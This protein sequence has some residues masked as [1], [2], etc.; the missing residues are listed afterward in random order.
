MKL[1]IK[2][3]S[4]TL[5][6]LGIA[7]DCHADYADLMTSGKVTNISH[8][9]STTGFDWSGYTAADQ[10]EHLIPSSYRYIGIYYN[11][12]DNFYA[13]PDT[14]I[15][16]D[17]KTNNY[18]FTRAIPITIE[19]NCVYNSIPEGIITGKSKHLNISKVISFDTRA[20]K[21][22]SV[23]LTDT[24]K[25]GYIGCKKPNVYISDL[26]VLQ[27]T[28][29]PELPYPDPY[30][31]A[32]VKLRLSNNGWTQSSAYTKTY[33]GVFEK[34]TEM[35]LKKAEW[36]R[37]ELRLTPGIISTNTFLIEATGTDLVP[38][39]EWGVMGLTPEGTC[40]NIYTI[41]KSGSAS[42]EGRLTELCSAAG[43]GCEIPLTVSKFDFRL[44]KHAPPG[45]YQ[46]RLYTYVTL[47]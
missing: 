28:T 17:V 7:A 41:V 36:S 4:A 26:T 44:N 43:S 19:L 46:C 33:T 8:T 13:S 6:A 11:S 21:S 40:D 9:E 18:M 34:V 23:P 42:Y 15:N 16:L 24:L 45:D 27:K 30:V 20:S 32:D 25:A 29:A 35:R 14:T 22:I 2:L 10:I 12:E 38:G 39:G 1:V 5:L 3:V 47:Y 37:S 31:T